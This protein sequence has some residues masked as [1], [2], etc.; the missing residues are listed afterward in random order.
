MKIG[1]GEN[2]LRV[3]I[4]LDV[5][6]GAVN[7]DVIVD[8]EIGIVTLFMLAADE[9]EAAIRQFC[10]AVAKAAKAPA[11]SGLNEEG[12]ANSSFVQ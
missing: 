12:P 11:G 9:D 5:C 1:R 6:V 10:L 8:V 2:V 3:A 7:D 4:N